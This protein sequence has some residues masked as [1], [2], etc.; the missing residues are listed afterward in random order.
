MNSGILVAPADTRT[1]NKDSAIDWLFLALHRMMAR[2]RSDRKSAQAR[3]RRE[4]LKVLAGTTT[5]EE[6]VK[7]AQVEGIVV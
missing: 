3:W 1:G 2:S 6:V 7:V 5:A 4:R